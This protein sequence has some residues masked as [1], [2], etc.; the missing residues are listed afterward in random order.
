MCERFVRDSQ[1]AVCEQ[2][3]QYYSGIQY[4]VCVCVIRTRFL[5]QNRTGGD[6][7]QSKLQKYT[8]FLAQKMYAS[9]L[10]GAQNECVMFVWVNI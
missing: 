9:R 10:Y 4:T 1:N 6:C 3:R 7:L 8:F 2:V 5:A